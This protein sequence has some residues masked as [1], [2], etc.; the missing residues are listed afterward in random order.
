ME[1]DGRQWGSLKRL[2]HTVYVTEAVEGVVNFFQQLA[3]TY[4]LVFACRAVR[5][6]SSDSEALKGE[7]HC[8]A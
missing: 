8:D 4:P 7:G 2:P 6:N 3:L 1:S 5:V